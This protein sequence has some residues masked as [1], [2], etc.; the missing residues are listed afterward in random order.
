MKEIT[1]KCD[2]CQTDLKY[3][4]NC[5]DYR[6]HLG[7]QEMPSQGGAVT[8]MMIYPPVKESDFCSVNCLKIF[9]NKLN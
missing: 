4:S 3:S 2:T 7:S 8:A 1:I 9:V 6:I 5:V